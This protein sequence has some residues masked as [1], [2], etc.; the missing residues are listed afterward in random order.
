MWS[1]TKG[2]EIFGNL[3]IYEYLKWLKYV[4]NDLSRAQLTLNNTGVVGCQTQRGQQPAGKLFKV[5]TA[6]CFWWSP[7]HAVTLNALEKCLMRTIVPIIDQVLGWKPFRKNPDP[8]YI[9][10]HPIG[11]SSEPSMYKDSR[12]WIE[13]GFLHL[14]HAVCKGLN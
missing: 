3:K 10:I 14:Q 5:R 13:N 8:F 4:W 1:N 7:F 6:F 12:P 9:S 11:L 2:G